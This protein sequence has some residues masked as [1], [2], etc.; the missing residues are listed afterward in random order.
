MPYILKMADLESI[1]RS[2][3]R[4]SGREISEGHIKDG[5]FGDS[6][7]LGFQLLQ[8]M[9]MDHHHQGDLAVGIM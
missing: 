4:W 1:R 2:C 9:P 6:F 8:L 3:Q 5:E 7:Y